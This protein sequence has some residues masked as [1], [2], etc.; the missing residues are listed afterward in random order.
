MMQEER[1]YQELKIP[2]SQ[3]AEWLTNL[4]KAMSQE[5]IHVKWQNVSLL[6]IHIISI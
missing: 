2:I 3:D 5:G 6:N 1:D 4:C